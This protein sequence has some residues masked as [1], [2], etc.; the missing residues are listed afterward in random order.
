MMASSSDPSYVH[1]PAWKKLGL[2][3]KYAKEGADD[4][5]PHHS[6][7]DDAANVRKRK[8]TEVIN[9]SKF[10]SSALDVP[11]RKQR[12]TE[13]NRDRSTANHNEDESFVHFRKGKVSSP[14]PAL[15]T[16]NTIR[17]SVSFT[18]ETKTQDGEGIKQ[19][20][21]TWLDKQVAIDSSFDPSD[22]SPALRSVEPA[23]TASDESASHLYSDKAEKTVINSIPP[24]KKSKKSK[25]LKSEEK[26]STFSASERTLHNGSSSI[27]HPA[28]NYLTTHHTSPSDWKFSKSQQNYILKHLFSL[29]HL[30]T[31]YDVKILKYLRG[32]QGSARSR[33][34]QQALVIRS[35]DADW[36]TSEPSDSEK[37][38][39]ETNA[40]CLARRKRDYDAAVARIKQQLRDQEDEREEKEWELL[41]DKEEWEQRVRKRRRAEVV[42]WSVGEDE[43]V[44][45]ATV[46]TPKHP[47]VQN[48][49]PP[50]HEPTTIQSRGMGGVK[51]I[52][53][54]GI[55]KGS[56]SKK[57]V[58][59]EHGTNGV[60][61][62]GSSEAPNG[63]GKVGSMNGTNDLQSRK[64]HTKKRGTK[65][66]TTGV[67]DDDD[68]STSES[69]SSDESEA[70]KEEAPNRKYRHG[71]FSGRM[72]L[73][74][75]ASTSE[76]ESGSGDSSEGSNSS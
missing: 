62:V 2:K 60:Q 40:Q 69:S 39:Q 20:Y 29:S 14:L 41:G 49:R 63:V 3:L 30:P 74:D 31:S 5:I 36:L 11:V 1:I 43:E 27:D 7:Q 68:S 64:K 35:E 28:L 59:D 6:E 55:A 76:S 67:P 23:T 42:L 70:E 25:K 22:V 71:Y 16:P 10:Q 37:M 24:A 38:D 51:E 9:G 21:K 75:E 32:L 61:N 46:P 56:A 19:L 44:I 47:I 54:S 73:S 57:I 48:F 33:V 65:K 8:L 15:R 34:R 18:P 26:K 53:T 72:D 52:S 4:A 58:F 13:F 66:R 17:K 12:K 50:A 45:E